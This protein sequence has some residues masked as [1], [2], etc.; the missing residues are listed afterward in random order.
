MITISFKST[1]GRNLNKFINSLNF[2]EPLEKGRKRLLE[3]LDR[4]FDQQG[5]LLQGGGFTRRGGAFA[6]LSAATTR[7]SAWAPLAQSTRKDRVRK[8]Y[9]AARPILERTGK[10]RKGFKAKSDSDSI[11]A[12]NEVSYGK[13]HQ[14]GTN[15][16][17]QRKIIG[18]SSR[19]LDY[20]IVELTRYISNQIR[21]AS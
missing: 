6:N 13:Y 21:K 7:G 9:N 12:T 15:K 18:F 5:A 16:M 17:P 10:L 20:L 8:G 19:F 14:S 1:S 11:I 3:D 4:N 2:K